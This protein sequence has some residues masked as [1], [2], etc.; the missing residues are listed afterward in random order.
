MALELL[1]KR[2]STGKLGN[3]VLD[4]TISERQSFRNEVTSFPI[5][6]GSSIADHIIHS[7]EEFEI[8]G[9][10]TNTPIQRLDTDGFSIGNPITD[11]Y[12][13]AANSS[14]LGGAQ[15]DRVT[16]AYLELLDLGGF[17]Y[18]LKVYQQSFSGQSL[19]PLEGS[20]YY[21]LKAN[22]RPASDM[23][24]KLITNYRIYD[25]MVLTNL[26]IPTDAKTGDSVKFNATFKRIVTVD[27]QFTPRSQATIDA[28]KARTA[29]KTASNTTKNPKPGTKKIPTT[30]TSQAKALVNAGAKIVG[31]TP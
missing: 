27:L 25:S 3:L 23:I 26:D 13:N 17:D 5:E 31:I 1:F 28:Q 15:G 11:V 24:V 12:Y 20:Q 21:N 8:E 14:L 9:V 29:K 2:K 4:A 10:V 6:N 22:L 16:N 18:P 7:P 30:E 19:L